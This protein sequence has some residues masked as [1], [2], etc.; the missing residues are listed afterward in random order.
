MFFASAMFFIGGA[1]GLAS[2]NNVGIALMVT[3]IAALIV[4][5]RK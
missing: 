1:I 3:G 4:A 2:G 5:L